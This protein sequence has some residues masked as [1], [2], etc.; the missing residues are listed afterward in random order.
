MAIGTNR[1]KVL[2]GVYEILFSDLGK[3]SQVVDVNE[4]T[5]TLPVRFSKR[6]STNN[7]VTA[8]LRNTVLPGLRF[9]FVGV[10]RDL[11]CRPFYKL[12]AINHLHFIGINVCNRDL[13]WPIEVPV[14]LNPIELVFVL[15]LRK[16]LA[17]SSNH[18]HRLPCRGFGPSFLTDSS[19]Q[20][21]G[22][23]VFQDLRLNQFVMD[24][25]TP[26]Q[27]HF[28]D[29]AGNHGENVTALPEPHSRISLRL[30]MTPYHTGESGR[31]RLCQR[32]EYPLCSAALW[33]RVVQTTRRDE[34]I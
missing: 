20:F 6:E 27:M 24:A 32:Q 3:L 31:K 8:I 7:A 13:F 10:D 4:S 14:V 34:R 11:S 16:S 5:K 30:I 22:D 17:E 12:C 2:D 9:P 29:N 28:L 1:T 21:T 19:N 15:G 33:L 25:P 26:L 23:C 18:G